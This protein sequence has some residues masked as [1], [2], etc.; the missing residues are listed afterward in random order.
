MTKQ[1]RIERFEKQMPF[2]TLYIDEFESLVMAVTKVQ[3]IDDEYM[4]P[5]RSRNCPLSRIVKYFKGVASFAELQNPQ[6]RLY[7]MLK[8]VFLSSKTYKNAEQSGQD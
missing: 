8:S 6:S 2:S 3:K 4:P 5:L 7:N 1:D